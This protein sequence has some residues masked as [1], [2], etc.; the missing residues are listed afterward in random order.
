[1]TDIAFTLDR[2]PSPVGELLAVTDAQGRLR[3]LDFEDYGP[4]LARLLARHYGPAAA[5]PP[6]RRVPAA[7]SEALDAYFAGRLD[8][9]ESISVETGGTDFQRRVWAALRRI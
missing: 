8:A 1:M 2:I 6:K 3:A 4:R 9:I 5:S 7:I